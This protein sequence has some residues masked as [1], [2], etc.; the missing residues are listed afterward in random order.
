M[1]NAIII[2]T[3]AAPSS[4][5]LRVYIGVCA[6]L[7]RRVPQADS[8]PG[9]PFRPLFLSLRGRVT[10]ELSLARELYFSSAESARGMGTREREEDS[11]L[12]VKKREQ[13]TPTRTHT[14]AARA[15]FNN[16]L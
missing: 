2:G 16:A 11:A 15:E 13:A 14:Y 5:C 10:I 7:H 9:R 8:L 6:L 3:P 4:L 12:K 1:H